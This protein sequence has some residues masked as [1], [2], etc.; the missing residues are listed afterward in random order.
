MSI[1]NTQ[2]PI[3]K[4]TTTAILIALST[5]LS[6]IKVFEMPLGGSVTL[7]SMLPVCLIGIIYGTT[8]AIA[9]CLLYGAIQ[10]F[11][12]NPF[13]W[14][15][16]PT[17]LVGCILFDYIVA[18]GVLCLAGLFRKHGTLGIMLGITVACIARFVSHFIS[19][20][21]VF[22]NLEQF[23]LFGSVFTNRPVLYSICYNGLYMLPELIITVTAAFLIFRSTA[24]R[25]YVLGEQ[26]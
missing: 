23:N 26:Q 11:L 19:G 3:Y 7:L 5:V 25:M 13:G 9:P 14:G 20:Y 24:V 15:L 22:K 1:A 16:T 4:I 12:G 21:V 8:Y 6:L 18:F 10:M 2:K 17:M